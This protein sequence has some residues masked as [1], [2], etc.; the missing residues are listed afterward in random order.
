MKRLLSKDLSLIFLLTSIYIIIISFPKLNF[1]RYH[2]EIVF[3]MLSF[4]FLGYSLIAL[5]R[6]E[7]NYRDILHK[8]VLILEFSVLLILSVSVVLKFSSLGLDLFLLVMVLS[9]ITMVLSISA[10][11]RRINYNKSHDPKLKDTD[12]INEKIISPAKSEKSVE[13]PRAHF[14]L[15]MHGDLILIEIFWSV[16]TII[17]F[18]ITYPNVQLIHYVVGLFYILLISGYSVQ[19]VIFPDKNSLGIKER[20][21]LSFG[22]S[23]PISSIIGLMLNYTKYGISIKSLLLPLAILTL[24]ISIY[25]HIRRTRVKNL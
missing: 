8:P 23:L 7:E 1:Y 2:L 25:A 5:L 11:I 16:F 10:Y 24:I 6:P 20:L 12:T 22:I 21:G 3:F 9:I 19:A 18:Y 17:S 15:S 4:L 14:K 13:K